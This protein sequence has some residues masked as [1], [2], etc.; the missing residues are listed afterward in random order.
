M[1]SI[2]NDFK[3]F[4][5]KYYN[6]IIQINPFEEFIF[7]IREIEYNI[8]TE[9]L[10]I[11]MENR[12]KDRI[13]DIEY[14]DKKYPGR[15]NN[16]SLKLEGSNTLKRIYNKLNSKSNLLIDS[17]ENQKEKL[18]YYSY[19]LKIVLNS[20][21]PEIK[22]KTLEKFI[23]LV[24]YYN[25][26]ENS[27]NYFRG[28][29]NSSWDLVQSSLRNT[30]RSK[31]KIYS[32]DEL[33]KSYKKLGVEDKYN[34]IIGKNNE[35]EKVAFFQHC[36]SFSPLIDF[37]S[38]IQVAT[39]FSMNNITSIN[40][41]YNFDSAIYILQNYDDSFRITEMSEKDLLN[42]KIGIFTEGKKTSND[43]MIMYSSMG[44]I[45][46][47]LATIKF[48]SNK[49][50]D[51]MKYQSGSF[52]YFNDY[53]I[54]GKNNSVKGNKQNYQFTKMIIDKNVKK[55]IYDWLKSNYPEYNIKYLMDPYQF[56]NE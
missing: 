34:K 54:D 20:T 49:S 3:N 10:L 23:E 53:I 2:L 22:I 26:P 45:S 29:S 12:I 43:Y 16:F 25:K 17:D 41:F 47:E 14:R 38:K 36:I 7:F 56:F 31:T 39:F 21:Y 35:L 32:F 52:V 5:E 18:Y 50:N 46:E 37:T 19:V 42:L 13:I 48:S 30:D 4:F 55:E 51:R 8:S 1:T 33:M 40:D 28:Q 27:N 44:K 9:E 6:D 15:W 24:D 11:D